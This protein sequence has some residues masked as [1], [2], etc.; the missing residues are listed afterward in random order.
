MI[1][2][3]LP[4]NLWEKTSKLARFLLRIQNLSTRNSSTLPQSPMKRINKLALFLLPNL[5]S[6]MNLTI[7]LRNI[8]KLFPLLQQSF[9]HGRIRNLSLTVN[10]TISKISLFLLQIPD[11]TLTMNPTIQP[12]SLFLKRITKPLLLFLLPKHGIRNLSSAMNPTMHPRSLFLKISKPLP[13]LLQHSF[14]H[15]LA[16]SQILEKK[17]MKVGLPS[18][19]LH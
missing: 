19:L 8:L 7:L 3:I 11:I 6:T 18:Q 12:L 16:H 1:Q 17:R 15:G 5:S 14:L 9:L 13:F 10:H 4:L 2:I